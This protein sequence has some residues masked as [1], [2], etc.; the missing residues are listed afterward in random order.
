MLMDG[1][2]VPAAAA[3]E[4]EAKISK[5]PP[6]VLNVLGAQI[7]VLG[8]VAC[9]LRVHSHTPSSHST[10]GFSTK[11]VLVIS[12]VSSG[13]GFVGRVVRESGYLLRRCKRDRV[14]SPYRCQPLEA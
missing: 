14:A 8:S 13:E 4:P 10:S 5:M 9:L 3:P 11:P 2:D 1:P 7:T 6:P 12:N